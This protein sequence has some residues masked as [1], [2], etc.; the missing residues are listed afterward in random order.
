[1]GTRMGNLHPERG[2]HTS[3][4]HS[5]TG[6]QLYP[7]MAVLQGGHSL[8][9]KSGGGRNC[10]D[11]EEVTTHPSALAGL[12]KMTHQWESRVGGSHPGQRGVRLGGAGSP[13]SWNVWPWITFPD[14]SAGFSALCTS[15]ES[16]R[17]QFKTHPDFT[18][19][20]TLGSR[21]LSSLHMLSLVCSHIVLPNPSL[22]KG[23]S[24]C[25]WAD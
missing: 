16:F 23:L 22:K 5:L 9:G 4:H 18:H 12:P 21:G 2:G 14:V 15:C 8:L 24:K 3:I 17:P 10:G 6:P 25:L 20:R 7:W 1:M 13:G 19:A 11:P